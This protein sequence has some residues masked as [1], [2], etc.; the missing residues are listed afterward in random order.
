MGKNNKIKDLALI[1]SV[2]VVGLLITTLG[3]SYTY[4]VDLEK[5][6]CDFCF[7]LNPHLEV[8]RNIV[9]VNWSNITL[10]NFTAPYEK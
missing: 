5:N 3:I 4:R 9:F 7:E 8:C 10:S 2:V 1:L 6:S